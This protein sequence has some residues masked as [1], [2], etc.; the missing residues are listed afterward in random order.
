MT[1]KHMMEGTGTR[2][3]IGMRRLNLVLDVDMTLVDS[4]TPN[5]GEKDADFMSMDDYFFTY[6]DKTSVWHIFSRPGLFRCLE[7]W[8]E[9]FNLFLY[10]H[11]TYNY[12]KAIADNMVRRIPGLVFHGIHTRIAASPSSQDAPSSTSPASPVSAATAPVV[13]TAGATSIAP[14]DLKNMGLSPADTIIIDDTQSVWPDFQNNILKIAPFD[15]RFPWYVTDTEL[16]TI[17][18]CLFMIIANHANGRMDEVIPTLE[19]RSGS[20]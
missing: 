18:G 3:D 11:G 6:R 17:S 20:G 9:M 10:S 1:T 19:P 16:E 12:C 15:V 14:K 2:T 8:S 7:L 5:T 4:I 13:A